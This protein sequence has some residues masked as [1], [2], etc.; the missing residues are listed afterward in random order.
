MKKE[1]LFCTKAQAT[2]LKS[3][4]VAQRS[5]YMW[6][7]L[8]AFSS[9]ELGEMLPTMI[10]EFKLRQWK[11]EEDGIVKYHA[12]YAIGETRGFRSLLKYPANGTTEA[13][14]RA[15]LLISL[16]ENKMIGVDEINLRLLAA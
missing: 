16:L 12:S 11:T 8:A 5:A 15:S 2:K 10:G 6:G 4:G 7:E 13:Q 9:P 14:A 3:L 1:D